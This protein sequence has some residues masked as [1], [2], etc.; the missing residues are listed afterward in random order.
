MKKR[1]LPLLM[2]A[3]LTAGVLSGCVKAGETSEEV[4][5]VLASIE[6]SD[7][8]SELPEPSEPVSE[9]SSEVIEESSEPEPVDLGPCNPLTGEPGYPE[10]K[11]TKRPVA[12]MVNN[13]DAALPQRGLA[14]AD[15][16]Y[17]VVTESG[18]TRLM[19]LFADPD[20]IP[21]VGPV[22]SARHYYVSMLAPYDP[23]YV[24]FGGSPAG[25]EFISALG[26]DNVD[27][28]VYSNSFYQDSWRAQNRGREHSFFIDGETI[29]EIAGKRGYETEASIKPLLTFAEENL[30]AGEDALNVH[31]PFSYSY[32]AGFDYDPERGVYTKKRNGYDHIDADTEEVLTYENIFILYT[33]VTS[34]QGHETR[35]EV[36]LSAGS[37][38]Y[39]AEGKKYP[40]RWSKGDRKN[41]FTFT[42]EDGTP[43]EVN[44]GKTYVCLTDKSYAESVTFVK[45]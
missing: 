29:A 13:I 12:I 41:Q 19:A 14:V 7:P 10:E 35:R 24:H 21:Y 37:G 27:G 42:L 16:V 30:P 44:R 18:I 25:K 43:V 45:E 8:S 36:D 23:V 4:S 11:L 38:W 5:E 17:E 34:Y 15:I 39:V 28:L 6:T 22:R 40:I 3:L 32:S 1:A 2:A 9:P 26:I 20:S 31:V 33:T